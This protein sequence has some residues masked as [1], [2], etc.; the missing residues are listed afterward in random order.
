ME[1]Q[2]LA[3]G[4]VPPHYPPL[5]VRQTRRL[6]QNPIRNVELAHIVQQRAQLD[7]AHLVAAKPELPGYAN[8]DPA[9]GSGVIACRPVL[10]LK[11]LRKTSY[12]A[13]QGRSVVDLLQCS[14]NGV[15]RRPTPF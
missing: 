14:K 4:R 3:R 2:A 7:V 9:D 1:Q 11:P 5:E 6:A 12:L 13:R 10:P 8:G 15:H